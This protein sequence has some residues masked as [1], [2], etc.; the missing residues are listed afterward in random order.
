MGI[1]LRYAC[2]LGLGLASIITFLSASASAVTAQ[3][4]AASGGDAVQNP[5]S[6]GVVILALIGILGLAS[7]VK[8]IVSGFPSLLRDFHDRNKGRIATLMMAG[9]ICFVFLVT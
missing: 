4:L 1:V 7:V 9:V 5:A 3:R 6:T 2:L 8:F